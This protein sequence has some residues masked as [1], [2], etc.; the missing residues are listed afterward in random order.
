MKIRKKE[1]VDHVLNLNT[2]LE[3]INNE[4]G[5][6]EGLFVPVIDKAV[7]YPENFFE[8]QDQDIEEFKAKKGMNKAS[9]REGEEDED[10]AKDTA[11]VDYTKLKSIARKNAKVQSTDLDS[12][13]NQIRTIELVYE[14]EQKKKEIEEIIKAFDDEIREM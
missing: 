7:E 3:E 9:A 11:E 2:R 8:I 4:L 6:K 5:V 1:I 14:K 12:E 13:F 10:K